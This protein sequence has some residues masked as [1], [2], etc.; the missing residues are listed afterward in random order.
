MVLMKNQ[1]QALPGR[2]SLNIAPLTH[3][4]RKESQRS[5]ITHELRCRTLNIFQTV[6][7]LTEELPSMYVRRL[8]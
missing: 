8:C 6:N 1:E 2:S 3:V 4:Q 5:L 7:I